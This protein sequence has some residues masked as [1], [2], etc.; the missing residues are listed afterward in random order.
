MDYINTHYANS[1]VYFTDAGHPVIFS[2]VTKSVWPILTATDWDTIWSAV[3]AHTDAYTASFKYIHQ[4][5]SFTAASYDNGRFGWVQPPTYSSTQQFWW[6]SSTSA[7]P[8]YLDSFYSA[9]LTHPSQLTI[10]ALWKGFDDNNASWG[11][12]RVIAEQCG[13]VLLNTANEISKYFGGSNPQL[14]YV[15]VVTWN[16]YEE[17]TAVEDGID[18][19][20]TVN[21]SLS[22]SQLTWSLAASDSYASTSTIHHF[23]VYY[24]DSAGNMYSAASNLPV[25]TGLLDL[26]SVVPTGTWTVYVEMVGQPLIINRMS[27]GVTYIH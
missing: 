11:R 23:N 13:Q 26:S 21:A 22:G 14:P 4:F 18:N 9:G 10:G 24:E 7:S 17:G 19:C 15:Q 25:A 27:N 3:K 5:G 2:F 20:Y 16:D 12:N 8:T 6:G 1:G